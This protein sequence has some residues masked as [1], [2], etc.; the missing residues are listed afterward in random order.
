VTTVEPAEVQPFSPLETMPSIDA[1]FEEIDRHLEAIE[2]LRAGIT[3]RLDEQGRRICGVATMGAG[4]TPMEVTVARLLLSPLTVVE[5]A[6]K[7]FISVN[8]VTTHRRNIYTKL[9]V[10]SRAAAVDA[11][12]SRGVT[13]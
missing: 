8:T 10:N 3:V 4:L 1:A 7:L 5:M 12:T 6:A 11:L 2:R 13:S 9:G